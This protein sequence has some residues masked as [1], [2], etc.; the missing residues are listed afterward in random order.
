MYRV[1]F[2]GWKIAARVGIPMLVRIEVHYDA[3]VKSYWATS[4]DLKGLVAAG[5]TLDELMRG[6]HDCIDMLMEEY[7]HKP[8][9]TKTFTA[10]NGEALTA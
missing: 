2:P 5:G 7:L 10:W 4:P 6:V 8:L 9:K 1:G 3:E